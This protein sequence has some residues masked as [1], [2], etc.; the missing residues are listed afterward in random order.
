MEVFTGHVDRASVCQVSAMVQI[1]SHDRVTRLADCKLY[2]HVGLCSGVGLYICIITAKQLLCSLD[3]KILYHIHAFASAI[4]TLCRI[5]LCIFIGQYAS[6]RCH[7]RFA[8]PVFRCDQLNMAVLSVL[9]I[10][11]GLCDLRIYCFY[12][13][14]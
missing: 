1:H 6:H 3:C 10:H 2:G 8:D 5:P 9:L 14:Q 13:I 12:F 4:I 11:N 7:D